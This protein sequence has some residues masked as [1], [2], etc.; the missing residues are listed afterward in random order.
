MTSRGRRPRRLARLLARRAVGLLLVV[1]FV[2]VAGLLAVL[3]VERL[4]PSGGRPAQLDGPQSASASAD[5]IRMGLAHIPTSNSC[6]LCHD[7]GGSEGLKPVPALGHPL[8][9]WTQC[10]TC[11]TDERLGRTAPGHTGIDQ[12]E[13]VNCHK[14]APPGPAITQAHSQLDQPCLKCHGNVAHLPTS[15]VGRNQDEC[16]LCHKPRPEPPPANPH[17]A[18]LQLECRSCHRSTDV[19]GLPIDHALRADSTCLLCHDLRKTLPSP[20]GGS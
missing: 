12:A 5:T 13:C 9:G 8:E 4:G 14:A 19:G 10:V 6:L 17:P 7:T 3:L 15:M 18:T 11:H 20:R 1:N 16:W 2:L